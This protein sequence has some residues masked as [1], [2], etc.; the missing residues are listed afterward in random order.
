VFHHRRGIRLCVAVLVGLAVTAGCGTAPEGQQTSGNS[1]AQAPKPATTTPA[2][3]AG[4]ATISGTIRYDG[5]IPPLRPVDMGADPLCA[6]KHDSAVP[7][8][9]LVV[10]EGGTLANVF[11]T[12]TSGLPQGEWPAPAE[13]V[14]MN[15][16]GCRYD[17]H[18][19]GIMVGQPLKILN[20]DGVLHNVHALPKTNK[21]F[22]MA[23]PASRTEAVET[24]NKVEDMFT[25]KCDVHPW[26]NA[27]IAVTSHPF[28][29]VTAD[30]GLFSIENLPA[31]DYEISAWHEKLGTQTA[32]LSVAD[33]ATGSVE[34]TFS[35]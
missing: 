2:P 18:V 11:V 15:Q 13:P 22:N 23:M 26:M 34:L 6:E 35:R 8:E 9:I 29:S 3:A 20:S 27:Y 10:G 31:G 28:F 7:S 5:D 1:A 16:Y 25:I 12:V 33:G 14:V 19:M 24:F 30:D 17:P 4:S 32:S 21:P